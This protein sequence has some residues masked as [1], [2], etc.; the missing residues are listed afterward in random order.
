MTKNSFFLQFLNNDIIFVLIFSITNLKFWGHSE[1]IITKTLMLLSD[2][3]VHFNSVR[4]LAK[5]E[6]VQFMLTHHTVS[7]YI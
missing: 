1:Q 3:S 6:E 7:V 5:L 2:L 4:K